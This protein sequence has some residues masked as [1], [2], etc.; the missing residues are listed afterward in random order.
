LERI[1]RAVVPFILA[2]V[3]ALIVII[4]WTGL[5]T[6]LPRIFKLG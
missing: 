2:M 4:Y 6:W 3:A 5:S 1:S